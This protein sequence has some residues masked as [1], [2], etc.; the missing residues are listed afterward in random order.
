MTN[1][2][3]CI[4]SYICL[5]LH[6]LFSAAEIAV[7][8]ATYCWTLESAYFVVYIF[9]ADKS[10]KMTSEANTGHQ[11]T[12]K[13]PLSSVILTASEATSHFFSQIPSFQ[14]ALLSD[15]VQGYK[16]VCRKC[17]SYIYVVWW[18]IMNA[19]VFLYNFE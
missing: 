13:R 2:I 18:W 1:I 15:H 16:L 12:N 11:G 19:C 10:T 14:V 9:N 17:C 7:L 5:N 8:K 6:V 4:Y 3:P